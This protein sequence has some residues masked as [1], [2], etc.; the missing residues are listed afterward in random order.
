MSDYFSPY[1]PPEIWPDPQGQGGDFGVPSFI[2]PDARRAGRRAAFIMFILAGV[3]LGC[4]TM[5]FMVWM[6]PLDQVPP[7][8]MQA[9]EKMAAQVGMSLRDC[10]LAIGLLLSIP[11]IIYGILALWVRTGR[12]A[13][14]ITAMAVNA[15]VL[16]FV[17]LSVLGAIADHGSDGLAAILMPLILAAAMIFPMTR[18]AVAARMARMAN[19]MSAQYWNQQFDENA[20]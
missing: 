11:G 20:E 5:F 4:A 2:G 13:G 9:M 18:L 12:L 16:A 3:A 7:E 17:A 19:A 6:M 10:F 15:I 14:I 1:S 8:Q